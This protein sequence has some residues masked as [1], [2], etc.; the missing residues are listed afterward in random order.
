MAKIKAPNKDYT[1]VSAGVSFVKGEAETED[2]WVI[3][4]FKNKGYEVEE[5]ELEPPKPPE[6]LT[7]D[8]LKVELD[9]LGI[10][11]KSSDK[12]EVLLALF[13]GEKLEEGE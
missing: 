3:G 12:K 4:W 6:K 7:V 10:E 8:E 11:Y 1:G 9:K 13:N 2:K 5:N